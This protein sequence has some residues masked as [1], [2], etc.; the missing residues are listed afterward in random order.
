V[1]AVLSFSFFCS[2]FFFFC[3]LIFC[4]RF[5]KSYTCLIWTNSNLSTLNFKI[6][7]FKHICK[8]LVLFCKRIYFARIKHSFK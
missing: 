7:C 4:F 1:A 6:R 8:G 5:W 3:F 2:V